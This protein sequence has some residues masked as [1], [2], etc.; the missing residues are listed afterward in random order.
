MFRNEYIYLASYFFFFFIEKKRCS[1]PRDCFAGQIC[2][3]GFCGSTCQELILLSYSILL[4][5]HSII[6]NFLI[7]NQFLAQMTGSV[8]VWNA[9]TS[10]DA[11]VSVNSLRSPP[12][13]VLLVC[14]HEVPESW[15]VI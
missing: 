9:V 15:R 11:K 4:N 3:S 12:L 7:L 2:E 14:F 13:S 10:I 5:A 8:L 6:L 1:S